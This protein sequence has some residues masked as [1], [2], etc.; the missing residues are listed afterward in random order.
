[1]TALRFRLNTGNRLR[2]CTRVWLRAPAALRA[3]TVVVVVFARVCAVSLQVRAGALH[4]L[5]F[6]CTGLC[7]KDKRM[8]DTVR[9]DTFGPL[10]THGLEVRRGGVDKRGRGLFASRPLHAGDPVGFYAG[11]ARGEL[12]RQEE[13]FAIDVGGFDVAIVP[14]LD[15]QG[16]VDFELHPMAASNEPAEGDVANMVLVGDRVYEVDGVS[17][18][19]LAFYMASDVY[20]NTELTWC[21]GHMYGRDYSAGKYPN[22]LPEFAMTL[23]RLKRLIRERP[24]GI[25]AVSELEAV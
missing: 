11:I 17:Y 21:Y 6:F 23:P 2:S 8:D 24:D 9:F 18:V 10:H 16:R 4:Y 25:F 12:T 7:F 15:S 3:S 14:P 5:K 1:L 22:V 20:A 19:V 13:A